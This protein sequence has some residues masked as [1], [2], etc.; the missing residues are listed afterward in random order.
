MTYTADQYLLR[1]YNWTGLGADFTHALPSGAI[2]PDED[3][4]Y[5]LT[6]AFL[7]NLTEAEDAGYTSSSDFSY[8]AHYQYDNF[9]SVNAVQEGVALIVMKQ[10][11]DT[12]YSFTN[13]FGDVA[14]VS[15]ESDSATGAEITFGGINDTSTAGFYGHGNGVDALTYNYSDPATHV[16]QSSDDSVYGDIWFNQNASIGWGGAS[17]GSAQ[18]LA[19]LHEMGHALGLKHPQQDGDGAGHDLNTADDSQKYTMMYDTPQ[20]WT[21]SDGG[22]NPY[23]PTTNALYNG[24]STTPLYAYGL[25]VNDIAAIQDIYGRN[26]GTRGDNTLYD[27][28]QGLGRAGDAS[29]AFIYAIWDGGGTNVIDT[30]GFTGAV[31]ID[32]RQGEFSSIGSNGNGQDGYDPTA[33]R[34]I[35]NVAIAYHTLIQNAITTQDNSVLVGNEWNNVLYA[36]GNNSKIYTD[37]IVYNNDTGFIAGVVGDSSDPNN[38]IPSIQNDLLIG[39]VGATTFYSGLGSNVLVAFYDQSVIDSATSSWSTYW[40]AA[41]QFTG[42]NN[43]TGSALATADPGETLYAK[44]ADYSQ[45]NASEDVALAGGALHIEVTITSSVITVNKDTASACVGTDTLYGMTAIVGTDGNDTFSGTSVTPIAYYGSK[46][47][48]TYSVSNAG[49]DYSTLDALSTHAHITVT[50]SSA[51]VTIDKA[52]DDGSLGEDTASTTANIIQGTSGDDSFNGF[53]PGHTNTYEESAGN[54]TYS[55]DMTTFGTATDDAVVLIYE[56][57]SGSLSNVSVSNADISVEVLSSYEASSIG[58]TVEFAYATWNAAISAYNDLYLTFT[59][60]FSGPDVETLVAGGTTYEFGS[61][62]SDTITGAS[63]THT[64]DGGPGTNTID[65]SA[66]PAG[67]TV[68]LATGTA[69]NG[70]GYT[71]TLTDIQNVI[72]SAHNDTITGDSND[73]VIDGGAGNNTL[74]GGGGTDTLDYSH[75]TAGV[76]VNLSTGTA[77]NGYGGTDTISNFE[78]VLGSHYNDTITGN[79]TAALSYANATASVTID[80][81]AGTAVGDGTDT[82]S[83]FHSVIGSDYDDLIINGGGSNT[84]DGGGGTN[85]LSYV[86]DPA[87]VTVDLSTGTA[88]NG[89]SG[90]DTIS[91]FQNVVGSAYDDVI[92]GDSND[93]VISGGGGNNTL[94][95]GGGINTLDY[96]HDPAGVTVDLSAGTATNGYGGSDTISNFQNVIG[97]DHGDTIT[98]SS[99]DSNVITC[100]AGDDLVIVAGSGDNTY[101]GGG[102]NNTLSYQLDPLGV[103]VDLSSGAVFNGFGGVDVFSNFQNVIGS[104]YDDTIYGDS[105]NNVISGGGGDN[106]LD[107]GGGTNTLDYSHDPGS[108]YVDLA[109]GWATNGWGGND[110]IANFQNVIGSAYGDTIMGS[111]DNVITCGA[112]DDLVINGGGSNTYDGGGGTNTLSYQYDPAGVTVDLST[113]TATNGSSGTDTIS[114]F[115]NVIG[116]GYDDTI[117]GDSQDNV[118]AGGAG[119]NTLDG[120]GGINTLD[121]SNAW[122]GVTVDLSAG[123]ASNGYGGTDTISNFQIVIGSHYDD[124]ITGDGTTTVSYENAY[125]GVTVDLSAGTATGDGNDTLINIQS[126]IGSAYDD[127]IT[128]DSNDNVISGGAGN[129]TLDGGGGVNTLDYSHDPSGVT[130][131][132]SSGTATNGYAGTDTISNFQVVIGSH[133]DNTITGDGSTTIDYSHDPAGVTVDL[134]AGTATNGWGGTD[135]LSQIGAVMGSHYDDTI[136]GD[137]NTTVSY[138]HATGAV[139]VDLSA[140]TATGDGSD[141]LVNIHNIIGSAYGDTITGDSSNDVISGGGGDNTLD[142]GGGINTLDYSHDPAGVTVDLADGWATNGW[143]GT[144]T[145]SNF[146]NVIGSAWG[147]NI[148]GDSNDNVISV[149][150]ANNE[151]DGNYGTNTVDYSAAPAGVTVDLSIGVATNDGFGGTDYLANFQVVIGSHHDDTITGDGTTA[152]SYAD[153]TGPVTVDLS[154]GTA[155]GDGNDTLSGIVNVT[156]SSHD[157]T[158]TGDSNDNVLYGNGGNDYLTGGAGADTFLFKGATA[159]TGVTT[160]ADFNTTDG[161]KLDIANVISTY[162]PLTMVIANFVQLDTS[163]SDTQVKVD[164]DGSGTS[165]TQ[166]A[167]LAGVT[168]LNLSDLITDGNLVVHHT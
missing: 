19:V 76:T 99:S 94:D 74:D 91:N 164:T 88:T 52:D 119:N 46:G 26:Y 126:V 129:N 69:S 92:T 71:D 149:R 108:V 63:G 153:A 165:F 160:I 112:G 139:T 122:D 15:F 62:Y 95:G 43:A 96:S 5:T 18:F 127:T 51:G 97:S 41:G 120:G 67:V 135:T 47:N 155:T 64:I 35:D 161:D 138:A 102:G 40:D 89:S 98:T 137:G 140:G 6:Y 45:L 100:G 128:G 109:D 154:A 114:N 20:G 17:P 105:N 68:D 3:G 1:T 157:D 9:A 70:W 167:T 8:M 111:S 24:S 87:G 10:D 37:G 49:I 56:G 2:T 78:I 73:N 30:T 21:P 162:D 163:G 110:A 152:V 115:Q 44:I 147:D 125:S 84:Y 42:S 121:Y 33:G 145:I 54:N 50:A 61:Y 79:G 22:P 134:S 107:G 66:A 48:D 158:I 12:D 103:F 159:E 166:I 34:D 101:D 25:Q 168:G 116:S 36:G 136:T 131:D 113:G 148:T 81:S 132:L 142:G 86:N 83:N 28:G 29:N 65:Y 23:T 58:M 143:S 39:G 38:S 13:F 11:E 146:Q 130:V 85:T 151:L 80:L 93:N 60:Y 133:Y 106:N 144:D 16:G 156:G 90:T 118:I 141:T 104:A 72:G 31:R 27:F 55:F 82:I 123:T 57:T 150:G 59:K 14:P 75:D 4:T 53:I 7:E 77:T 117:T 124:S 32:L